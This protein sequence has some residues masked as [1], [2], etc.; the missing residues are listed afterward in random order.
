MAMKMQSLKDFGVTTL[1][2]GGH[3]TCKQGVK[4]NDIFGI[5]VAIF[6]IYC[7]TFMGLR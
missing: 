6:F 7:T 5:F 1:T 4:Y 3:V 2:F